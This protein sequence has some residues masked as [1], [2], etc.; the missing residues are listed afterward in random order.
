MATLRKIELRGFRSI[1][2]LD[3][4]LRPLNVLIGPNG[5]GKSNF[6]AFFTM[7]AEMMAGRLQQYIATT[8]RAQS[9][10]HYGPKVT[11]R[12]E[13]NLEF[14]AGDT[15]YV[16]LFELQSAV[17]DSLVVSR[18]GTGRLTGL[19]FR[20]EAIPLGY[21]PPSTPVSVGRQESSL[22][23]LMRRV[24]QQP[25]PSYE[26]QHELRQ[27][28]TGCRAYHFHDTSATARARQFGYLH[29]NRQLH[30][31]AGNLAAMLY[32]YRQ[33]N[34]VAYRRIVAAVQK[35]MPEFHDFDL[36]PSRLNQA[37]INLNWRK[38][39]HDYLFGPHQLSDGSLRAMAL[40]TLF[41]QPAD[42]LPGLLVLDEPELG[43]HPFALELVAGLIRAA[44]QHAQV[45]VATQ[46]PTFL[47]FFDPSEIV[48]VDARDGAS[49]FRR[50]DPDALK[51][52][53]ED[54]T[55]GELWQRNVIGGGPLP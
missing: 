11:P 29:D 53:L 18:E 47:N 46:S 31:D 32:R 26:I 35:L 9:L 23:E 1:K 16:Y 6:V 52:W 25:A 55:V 45:V 5:A 20:V 50:L 49:S 14:E 39:G 41:L 44:S 22:A 7:L 4:E 24:E 3:L 37:E 28:L 43:L 12:L 15:N 10:L 34:A 27:L 36:E 33:T 40:C 51:E 30:P 21:T 13:A 48:V 17:G 8:G 42:E 38:R 2:S 54:Y 19:S